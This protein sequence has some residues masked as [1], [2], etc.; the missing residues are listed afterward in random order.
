MCLKL[1]SHESLHFAAAVWAGHGSQKADREML[2]SDNIIRIR[3]RTRRWAAYLTFSTV[4]PLVFSHGTA[5]YS[6]T[7]TK[8]VQTY[9]IWAVDYY[10]NSPRLVEDV[11]TLPLVRI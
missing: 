8:E 10:I 3:V 2:C 9:F 6:L 11:V 4:F 5:P 7:T 1:L